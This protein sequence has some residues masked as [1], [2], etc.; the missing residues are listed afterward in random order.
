MK[1]TDMTDEND[2]LYTFDTNYTLNM[3]TYT[4]L[5]IDSICHLN[6]IKRNNVRNYNY[7]A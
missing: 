5:A 4:S 7:D 2:M 1:M 6:R 3:I